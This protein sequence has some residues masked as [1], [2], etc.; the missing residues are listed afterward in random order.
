MDPWLPVCCHGTVGIH[1]ISRRSLDMKTLD[2]DTIIARATPVAHQQA[3]EIQ[4]FGHLVRMPIAL[5]ES[6][7]REAVANLNQL[8]ADT[9]AL[10]DL[11]KKHHWQVAGPTFYQLHLLFDKHYEQQSELV[12][13]IAERIQL[14]GGVSIAMAHDVAETTLVPRPPKGREEVPVQISRLL[15]AHEIVLKEA[16]TMARLAAEGGDDG[17]NDLLVS[18]VIRRNELQVW[19]LAEHVV[20]SPLVRA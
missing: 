12:D 13:A 6:A 7:C 15:H 1:T 20:D 19:F 2:A 5:S 11:Y 18:D 3:H 17:T 16:R 9:T 14:L 8:L 4:P 10:R